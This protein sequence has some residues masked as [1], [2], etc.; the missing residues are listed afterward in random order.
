NPAKCTVVTS[1]S[2]LPSLL[3]YGQEIPRAESYTY[4]GFPVTANGIDFQQYLDQRIQ[5]AV[6]RAHWLGVQSNS[7]GPAHRLRIY[8]QFLTP[9]FEYS[10]PL[11]WA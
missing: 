5:A 2:D 8:K 7:W 3:V 1:R 9:I 10:A 6:G 11:V 4:L